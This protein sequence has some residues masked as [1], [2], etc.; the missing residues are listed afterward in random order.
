VKSLLVT[1]A[2]ALLVALIVRAMAPPDVDPAEAERAIPGLVHGKK[3]MPESTWR[4]MAEG[5]ARLLPA[6]P[7]SEGE[8][9]R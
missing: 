4:A 2:F 8:A 6:R 7:K 3:R 5:K 1:V 9:P